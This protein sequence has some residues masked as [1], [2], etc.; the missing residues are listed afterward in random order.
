M[1]RAN[2]N[3]HIT[4]LTYMLASMIIIIIELH[5]EL[6]LRC[7]HLFHGSFVLHGGHQFLSYS[8]MNLHELCHTPVEADGL[9]F[10]Q[11]SL[12]VLWRYALLVTWSWQP[13]MWRNNIWL[14]IVQP[15]HT[16]HLG[17]SQ[18]TFNM[19]KCTYNS[20]ISRPIPA[21]Q[22]HNMLKLGM[23]LQSGWEPHFRTDTKAF[24]HW[25]FS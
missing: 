8:V 2:T 24:F 9:S 13:K 18:Q 5:S 25:I 17:I 19:Y 22:C 14:D 10:G 23:T 4:L 15:M 7:S 21:F 16:E 1:K 12:V 6:S 20:L 3:Q 11:F